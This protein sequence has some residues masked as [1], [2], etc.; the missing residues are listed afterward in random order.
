M[1]KRVIIPEGLEEITAKNLWKLL[2]KVTM[3][4]ENHLI[5]PDGDRKRVLNKWVAES[6]AFLK[7][8]FVEIKNED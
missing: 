6:K 7:Y 5:N 1:N 8:P 4:A 3:A 2:Y